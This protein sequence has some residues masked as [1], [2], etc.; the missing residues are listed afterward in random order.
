[1]LTDRQRVDAGNAPSKKRHII[2]ISPTGGLHGLQKSDGIQL[3]ALG[4][5]RIRRISEI[6][7]DEAE[8]HW[9]VQFIYGPLA[10]RPVRGEDLKEWGVGTPHPDGGCT[11]PGAVACAA[12]VGSPV[13]FKN[14][15]DGVACEVALVE[16]ASLKGF[17]WGWA[18][19][20]EVTKSV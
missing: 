6:L 19:Q 12:A 16:A 7:W 8:Q 20:E 1:M 18:E 13:F 10:L 2:T 11:F 3:T 15:A 14:Y 17:Y 4:R 9:Y 5:A